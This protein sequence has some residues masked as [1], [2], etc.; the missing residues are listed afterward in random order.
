V[1]GEMPN[2]P[3]MQSMVPLGGGLDLV[4]PQLQ[5]RPGELIDCG[6]YVPEITGGYRRVGGYERFDGRPSPSLQTYSILTVPDSSQLAVGNTVTGATS[7]ATAKVLLIES[8]NRV[9][10]TRVTGTFSGGEVLRVSGVDRATLTSIVA[11]AA[12]TPF[13][14]ATYRSLTA[15]EYRGD[16]Q[17]VPGSGPI[18]GVWYFAGSLYAFRDNAGGTACVMHRAT[19]GGWVT[20]TTPALLPGGQYQFVNYN[21]TGAAGG[22]RMYGCDGVNRAFQFD[23]TTFTQITST[24]SPDA[25]QCIT[26]HRQRLFLAVRGSLFCSGP[27]NPITGWAGAG[28][29]PAEIGI[30]DVI[31]GLLPMQGDGASGSLAVYARN[32]TAILYGATSSD[33]ALQLSAPDAGALA[34][35]VQYVSVGLALDDRGV[36]QMAATQDYGNFI[37]STISAKVQPF[38]STRRGLATASSVLRSQNHYRIY[39]SDGAALC[40]RV[41]NGQSAGATAIFYPN[42]VSC[43]YSGEDASG[44]EVVFFGS[45]NGFVYQ[46]E[47]GTSFDGQEIEAWI[48]TGFNS[49][50]SP[51]LRKKWRRVALE[52]SIPQYMNLFLTYEQDY[53][54]LSIPVAA[55]SLEQ[56][57]QRTDTPGGG[58][59]WDQFTWDEFTWDSPLISPPRYKL[60]GVS[61]NISLLWFSKD[62][63]SQPWT[64]QSVLLH[65]TPRRMQRGRWQ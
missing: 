30:G 34:N 8:A 49:E 63:I 1:I 61:Q 39:F 36:T 35:T 51:S 11:G 7:A 26:A 60:A 45:T 43:I 4:S 28:T 10:V 25:P 20:V 31:T 18:R 24:A 15:D 23:G 57:A 19:S 56:F 52:C 6:N 50:R 2:V 16:I 40:F 13:L 53:G 22:T 42:P 41:E 59:F 64:L 54:S 9:V 5:I 29:T 37:S 58:G 33:F 12:A 46:A 48:R 14:D 65:Y 47:V 17:A 62:K 27:G 32:R 38:I 44:A 55:T 21:F 3:V